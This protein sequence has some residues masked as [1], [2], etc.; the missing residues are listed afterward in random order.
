MNK[1]YIEAMHM[2]E[3]DGNAVKGPEGKY[4]NGNTLCL[5]QDNKF[6][7][8]DKTGNKLCNC[9]F[10]NYKPSTGYAILFNDKNKLIFE[11]KIEN[12]NEVEGIFFDCTLDVDDKPVIVNKK[13]VH[14]NYFHDNE[15]IKRHRITGGTDCAIANFRYENNQFTIDKNSIRAGKRSIF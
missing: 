12:G 1:K 4:M 11:G 13:P 8:Y 5:M 9:S 10:E 15:E 2:L 6:T 14:E 7:V 3:D